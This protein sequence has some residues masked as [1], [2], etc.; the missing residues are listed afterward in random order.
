MLKDDPKFLDEVIK[1]GDR[2]KS[3]WT[4]VGQVA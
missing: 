3:E 2:I 4:K 1:V